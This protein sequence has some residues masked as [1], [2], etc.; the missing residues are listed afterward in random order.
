ML[1]QRQKKLYAFLLEKSTDNRYIS[2]EEISTALSEL[3]PRNEE[4]N[5]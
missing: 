5:K 3:Y 4:K 1:N 2:K